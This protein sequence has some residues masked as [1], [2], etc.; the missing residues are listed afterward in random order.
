MSKQ[1]PDKQAEHPTNETVE[2]RW[3]QTWYGDGGFWS[4]FG[5]DGLSVV[6]DVQLDALQTLSEGQKRSLMRLLRLLA[7][8]SN[9]MLHEQVVAFATYPATQ[10]LGALLS[11]S[12][13][14]NE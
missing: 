3:F 8:P 4:D 7:E 6:F 13:E 10:R 9:S 12:A 11:I 2:S 14:L 5:Y 1:Q